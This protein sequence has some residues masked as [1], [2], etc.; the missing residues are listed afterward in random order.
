MNDFIQ[1]GY[2]CLIFMFE[3]ISIETCLD[4]VQLLQIKPL[5]PFSLPT[6]TVWANN[7]LRNQVDYLKAI[8]ICIIYNFRKSLDFSYYGTDSYRSL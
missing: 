8:Y 6:R 4:F 1:I 5:R 2:W 3:L 7:T